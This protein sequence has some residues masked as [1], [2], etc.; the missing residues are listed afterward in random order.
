MTPTQQTALEALAGRAMTAAEVTLATQ[1]EDSALAA[2]LSVGL[3]ATVSPTWVSARTV[4]AYCT[5][6]AAILDALAGAASTVSAVKWA[7][8]YIQGTDG[9]D[10]GLPASIQ[11]LNQLQAA[12]VLTTAQVTELKNLAVK[13]APIS[14]ST[15]SNI[16]N[17]D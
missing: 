5:D 1:R 2:S 15:V 7:L 8:P 9:I 16:L 3:T 12:N 17:G 6:G 13:P 10:M 14:V 4:L 11:M